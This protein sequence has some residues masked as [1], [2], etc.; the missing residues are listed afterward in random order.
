MFPERTGLI[1]WI[2]DVKSSKA[3]ERYGVIHYIS[4]KMNYVVLYVNTNHL[5]ETMKQ[6]E[7]FNFVKKIER[8]FRSEIK[9][10]YSKKVPD[11]TQFYTY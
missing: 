7:K 9:T 8:S 2:Q 1:L 5:E 3:L 6:L 10:E 11:Q 4:K